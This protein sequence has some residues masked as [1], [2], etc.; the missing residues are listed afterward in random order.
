MRQLFYWLEWHWAVPEFAGG[1]LLALAVFLFGAATNTLSG[2]L[3]VISGISIAL[4]IVG[5]VFPAR[6][7]QELRVEPL[8]PPA[9]SAGEDLYVD[10]VIKNQGK[11]S[12]NLLELRHTL[13][14]G[15]SPIAV[16]EVVVPSLRGK[17]SFVWS[18]HVPTKRRGIYALAPV[19]VATASPLGLFRSRRYGGKATAKV[20]VYPKVLPLSQCPL[21]DQMGHDRQQRYYS[22]RHSQ[23]NATEGLTRT[24]R[25]YQWGDPMRMIHWRTSARFGNLQV[26]ELETTIGGQELLIAVDLSPNWRAEHFEQAMLVSATLYFYAL[27][28]NLQVSLWSEATGRISGDHLV[29]EALAGLQIAK[30]PSVLPSTTSAMLLL[31]S[32]HDL[33]RQLQEGDRFI[34][35]GYALENLV[36]KGIS[37][38]PPT[39]A[40]RE[41][42]LFWQ[43][44]LQATL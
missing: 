34:F 35:W 5:A 27:R 10:I 1:L 25:P 21:I 39:G 7:I 26:R 4:L 13:P 31:T 30:H 32:R 42:E 36:A 20:V 22:P 15:L 28:A 29:L 12:K 24:L 17:G 37:A 19:E 9:V 3:Y 2:W 44:N 16:Q 43:K 6:L 41:I 14:E 8:E 23:Q 33:L 18:Y 40:E 11:T 38:D